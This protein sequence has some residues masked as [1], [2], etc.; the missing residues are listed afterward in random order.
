MDRQRWRPH[1]VLGQSGPLQD[2]FQSIDVAVE[3]MPMPRLMLGEYRGGRRMLNPLRILTGLDYVRQLAQTLRRSRSD[4]LHANSLR[5]C[6]VGG[7]AARQAG[8]ASVWHIHSVVASP[9]VS[10]GGAWL[11]HSLARW[12]PAHI[13]CTSAATAACFDVA[14]D[15]VSVIPPGIDSRRFTPTSGSRRRKPVIGMVGRI[16]PLKGQHVFVEAAGTLASRYPDVEFVVAG[17]PLFG[18]EEYEKRIREQAKRGP[19]ADRIRFLGF[20]DDVPRLL[21]QMDVVVQASTVV[22]GFGQVVVEAMMAGK[23]V[24]GTPL[25]GPAEIVEDGITGRLVV[26][27]RPNDLAAAIEQMLLDPRE[28]RRMGENGRARALQFYDLKASTRAVENV[29]EQVLSRC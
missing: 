9:T 26:P 16:T 23:P 18:E 17:S 10:Y 15:R 21:E 19:A 25:G 1:V 4:L 5:A 22:E 28:A 11:L 3:V 2:R 13:I 24:I 6:V 14:A 20:V 29:Y 27:E 8:I 7:L 12:L